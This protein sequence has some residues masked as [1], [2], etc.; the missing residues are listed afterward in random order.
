MAIGK[1][2]TSNWRDV[3]GASVTTSAGTVSMLTVKESDNMV[4]F[5]FAWTS[6]VTVTEGNNLFTGSLNG[7]TCT[8][9][10]QG[11]TY[12]GNKIMITQMDSGSITVRQSKGQTVPG[13]YY[14]FSGYFMK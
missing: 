3:S 8:G 14:V 11:P 5:F 1:I 13:D 4:Y 2:T 7:V 10:W 6:D 12:S 9:V